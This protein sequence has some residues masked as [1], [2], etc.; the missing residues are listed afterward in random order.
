MELD[1]LLAC[2]TDGEKVLIDGFQR[3][4]QFASFLRCVIHFKGNIKA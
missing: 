4:F 3:N 2:R 1:A